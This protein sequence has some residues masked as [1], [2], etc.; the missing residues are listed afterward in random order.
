[1]ST[2]CI[3]WDIKG[4]FVESVF[5]RGVRTAFEGTPELYVFGTAGEGYAVTDRQFE[6]IVVTFADE[7]RRGGAEPMVGV[8]HLSQGTISNGSNTAGTQACG[9]FKSRCQSGARWMT[10]SYSYFFD[11]ICGRFRD[12][13]CMHF[14]LLRAKR[15]VT[16]KEYGRLAEAL[17]TSL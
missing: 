6:R 11:Q 3:P 14:N 8:F 4:H 2:C 10:G 15:I 9:R 5:R 12:C 16:G 7:M 13:R 1:M 17:P